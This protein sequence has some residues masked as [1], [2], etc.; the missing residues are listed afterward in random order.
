MSTTDGSN[1]AVHYTC[2]CNTS[3]RFF[4]GASMTKSRAFLTA[5]EWSE[6]R[7][8]YENSDDRSCVLICAAYIDRCLEILISESLLHHEVLDR[9]LLTGMMPLGTFSARISLAFCLNLIPS[10]YHE[11]FNTIRKIRNIFAHELHGISFDTES[12]RSRC[13]ALSVPE[14]YCRWL[15]VDFLDLSSSDPKEPRTRFLFTFAVTVQAL[16]G[17]YLKRA[18]KTRAALQDV[19]AFD[20]S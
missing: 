7:R 4:I 5:A 16:E 18:K 20:Q 3:S 15:E 17:H 12:V 6:F 10:I 19:G 8:E 1:A 2:T 14:D 11:D 13:A 9:S